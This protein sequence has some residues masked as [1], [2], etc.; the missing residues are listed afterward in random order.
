MGNV[1]AELPPGGAG[2]KG[3]IVALLA[4]YGVANEVATFIV[5]RGDTTDELELESVQLADGVEALAMLVLAD[6]SS[7]VSRDG[8]RHWP[9]RR[10]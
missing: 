7:V 6:G 5:G 2:I 8:I 9:Q 10:R 1:V 3:L 4:T